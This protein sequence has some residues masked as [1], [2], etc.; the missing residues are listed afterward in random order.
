MYRR[1]SFYKTDSKISSMW[2]ERIFV[3]T[4]IHSVLLQLCTT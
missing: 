3:F 4:T 2:A 1:N